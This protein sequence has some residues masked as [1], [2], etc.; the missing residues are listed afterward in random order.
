M[1][2]KLI[3]ARYYTSFLFEIYIL[4]FIGYSE[5]CFVKK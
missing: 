3:N 2:Y 4:F 1:E 5:L